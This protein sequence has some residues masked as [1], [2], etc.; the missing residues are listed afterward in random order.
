MNIVH[1]EQGPEPGGVNSRDENEIARTHTRIW[2]QSLREG[3]RVFVFAT[4]GTGDL[5]DGWN[6]NTA[7]FI[8]GGPLVTLIGVRLDFESVLAFWS[9]DC[10]CGMIVVLCLYRQARGVS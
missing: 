5:K 8:V 2:I 10:L 7:L 1:Q 4:I 9:N 3:K 6:K